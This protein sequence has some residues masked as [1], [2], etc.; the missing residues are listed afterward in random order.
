M[1]AISTVDDMT[2]DGGVACLDFVNS[3][4]GTAADERVERLHCYQDLLKLAART[5]L[6]TSV[7]LRELI[8]QERASTAAAQAVFEDALAARSA[9]VQLFGSIADRTVPDLAKQTLSSFNKYMLQAVERQS[10]VVEDETIILA[11]VRS[12]SAFR[13]PLD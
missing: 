9:M 2:L 11:T 10:F 6:I 8:K 3:G 12:K 7:K 4:L 5:G 13:E 1:N